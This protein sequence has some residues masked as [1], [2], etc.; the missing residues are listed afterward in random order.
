MSFAT[1]FVYVGIGGS[2][3]KIGKAFERLL[4][5]EICGPDGR[6]LIAR[7]GTFSG[8]QPRQLPDFVQT[9]YLDFSEQDLVSLQNDLL[10][11]SPEV[12]QKTATFV[13]SLGSAGRSSAEVTDLLRVSKTSAAV[14]ESWLPPKQSA[15]GTEPVFAPLSTGAGQYPTIGRAALFAY[16]EQYGAESLLRDFRRPLERIV[17]SIGQLEEYAGGSAASRNVV[18]L[19]GC[20]LS[21]GTGGGIFLDVIRLIAHEA[22]TQ[23]GGTPFVIVPLVLL[24]SA[25]DNVL[26]PSKRKHASLNATRALADLGRLIDSQNA[27]AGDESQATCSYPGGHGG[28]GMLDVIL[29]PATVKT[30]FLF[31]RPADIPNDGALSERVARFAANLLRQPS[32]SKLSNGPL[33]S[34]RTMTLLDKL[35][36][37][38]GL[39]QERHPTFIGRRPFASAACVAI[40]DGRDELIQL[41]AEQLLTAYAADSSTGVSDDDLQRRKTV[42]QKE[43]HLQPPTIAPI[44]P[45]WRT[46]VT[47]MQLLDQESVSGAVT[48]YLKAIRQTM[49]PLGE[50]RDGVITDPL[51]AGASAAF[52]DGCRLGDAGTN[53]VDLLS[54]ASTT[55]ETDIFGMLPAARATAAAW[56]GGQ[57]VGKAKTGGGRAVEF[58]DSSRLVKTQ[59]SGFLGRKSERVP[60]PDGIAAFKRAEESQV[61]TTWRNYLQ[62]PKGPSVKFLTAAGVLRSRLD[63]VGHS[64][65]QWGQQTNRGIQGDIHSAYA[66]RFGDPDFKKLLEKVVDQLGRHLG[67]AEPTLV[68]VTQ[69][70]LRRRQDE[71]LESWKAQDSAE[72]ALLPVRLLDAVKEDVKLAFDEPQ[73]YA[74]ID[75]IL[76]EWADNIDGQFSPDVQQFRTKMLAAITDS[77]VPPAL[78]RD[79]EPMVTIAYPGEQNSRVEERLASALGTHAAFA[80]Y[81]QQAA[82]TFVPRSA[83]NALIVTV[84]LV[85]QGLAD[86]PDGASGLN[87]WVESAFQPEPTDRLAWRQRGGYKDSIDF[88]DH[89]GR[90]DLLQRLLAAAWNGELT[91]VRMDTDEAHAGAFRSLRLKFGASDAPALEISLEDMPFEGSLAPL[92][93][94]YLR[95]ISH[96]YVTDFQTVAEI[97]RELARSVPAGFVQR[98]RPTED[99][100][101]ARP[102]FLAFVSPLDLSAAG[103]EERAVLGSMQAQLATQIANGHGD[104]RRAHQIQEYMDFWQRGVPDALRLSFGTLGYGTFEEVIDDIRQARSDAARASTGTNGS[105][106]S[107]ESLHSPDN[108]PVGAAS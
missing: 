76:R 78:D 103:A 37:N 5:E 35:V 97:L 85:G 2:G 42:F 65:E 60:D 40:P 89:G 107:R 11:Q 46:G 4:R 48:A 68:S 56:A 14:T 77:L 22:S 34:G 104:A 36:N 80:R 41:V 83:G 54:R 20:S 105:G 108:S 55:A 66:E 12:A 7:G 23:L 74:G 75:Q 98:R 87:T 100:L 91:G 106:P 21:G 16:M 10:P 53:W 6:A 19:V 79:I 9:L 25:F 13:K 39:L 29:P 99:N 26:A 28:T 58:P 102:L 43:A 38:A 82:P 61:D 49:P 94:A 24:P 92:V 8:L 17:T 101:A 67:I 30:A 18:F 84:S 70:V 72:P 95:A 63:A 57:L 47:S 1:R 86:V 15:W 71:I 50:K 27:P 81:L 93:D 33:G 52:N 96:R 88:I 59:R 64:L 51:S 32:M 44:D 69:Q 90:A 45:R 3:L 73:V 31:H 62:N